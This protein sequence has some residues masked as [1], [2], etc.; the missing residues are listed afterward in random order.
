MLLLWDVFTNNAPEAIE[1]TSDPLLPSE[2][3]SSLRRRT[4]RTGP[5]RPP[6]TPASKSPSGLAVGLVTVYLNA[7]HAKALQLSDAQR[8]PVHRRSYRMASFPFG[9]ASVPNSPLTLARLTHAESFDSF[10]C[11]RSAF[12]VMNRTRGPPR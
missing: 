10:F 2:G 8:L 11:V 4:S 6:S 5:R 1:L 7:P 12:H 9:D 3:R